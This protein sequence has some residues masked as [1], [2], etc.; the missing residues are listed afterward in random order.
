MIAPAAMT[1]LFQ[2]AWRCQQF[3]QRW[4]PHDHPAMPRSS[5]LTGI[6][7]QFTSLTMNRELTRRFAYAMGYVKRPKTLHCL[8]CNAK[9]TVKPRGRLPTFCSQ[10]CRQRAYEQKKWSRPHPVELLAKDL[11][12]ADVR[13]A[14]RSEAL[15]LFNQVLKH[16]GWDLSAQQ[17]LPAPRP[18]KKPYLRLVDPDKPLPEPDS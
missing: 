5:G 14:I 2:A 10:S 3:G 18:K 9:M 4:R 13:E 8:R 16:L 17:L 15:N 11:A 1:P 12:R 6:S 7:S